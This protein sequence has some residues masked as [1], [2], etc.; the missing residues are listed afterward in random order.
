[1]DSIRT[2]HPSLGS[3]LGPARPSL[4]TRWRQVGGAFALGGAAGAAWVAAQALAAGPDGFLG[5]AYVLNVVA[6]V[7]YGSAGLTATAGVLLARRPEILV[8]GLAAAVLF[9]GAALFGLGFV[10]GAHTTYPDGVT[11]TSQ[12]WPQSAFLLLWGFVELIFGM[13]FTTL[14][15][16]HEWRISHRSL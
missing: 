14:R 15:H 8:T 12:V 5:A 3:L 2:A 6:A 10:M 7:T 4:P 11:V 9:V 1:M 13:F 16:Q